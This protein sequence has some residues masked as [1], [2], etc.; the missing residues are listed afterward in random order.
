MVKSGAIQ[1]SRK[2]HMLLEQMKFFPRGARDDGLDVLE[3]AVKAAK[4]GEFE[5]FY[6]SNSYL[7]DVN[8]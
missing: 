5:R 3:M 6:L 8:Y 7:F 4:V 1:F 2:H